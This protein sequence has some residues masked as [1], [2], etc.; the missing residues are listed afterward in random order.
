MSIAELFYAKQAQRAQ[1]F[2]ALRRRRLLPRRR[3]VC[4]EPLEPR[5]LLAHDP[6][7]YA[8]SG[9]ALNLTLR[10]EQDPGGAQILLIDDS[11]GTPAVVAQQALSETSQILITGSEWDDSLTVDLSASIPVPISFADVSR[12]DSDVLKV[13]GRDATW[14]ITGADAGTTESVTFAGV[15]NL[16]GAPNNRDTFVFNPGGSIS[17]EI[18]GGAGGYDSLVIEGGTYASVT[19]AATGPDSGTITLDGTTL[20]YEGLEPITDSKIGRAHV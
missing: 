13:V 1:M 8:A 7:S 18:E 14:D 6:L 19:Y 17:G 2:G 15:E 16:L 3:K 5:L 4:I 12:T 11:D 10:L 9:A 20:S